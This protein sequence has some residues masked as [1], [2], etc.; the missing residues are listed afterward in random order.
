MNTGV[1]DIGWPGH[2]YCR[3]MGSLWS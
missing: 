3:R 2:L 1:Q